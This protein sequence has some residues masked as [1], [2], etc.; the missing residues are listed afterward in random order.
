MRAFGKLNAI[1]RRAIVLTHNA[2]IS[3]PI[4][5]IIFFV[6]KRTKVVDLI[7]FDELLYQLG[8]CS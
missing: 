4:L 2:A 3:S 8:E 5:T 6:S 1:T 7:S